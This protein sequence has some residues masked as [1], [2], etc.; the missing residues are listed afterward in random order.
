MIMQTRCRYGGGVATPSVAPLRTVRPDLDEHTDEGTEPGRAKVAHI[1]KTEPGES[2][3]AKVTDGIA[4]ERIIFIS[5]P[6]S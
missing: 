5:S 1:V 2:A 4:S 6:S 3:I